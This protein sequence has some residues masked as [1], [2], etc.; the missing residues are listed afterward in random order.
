MAKVFMT[1]DVQFLFKEKVREKEIHMLLA[2]GLI[3]KG[4]HGLYLESLHTI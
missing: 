3:L 2:R 4:M 1:K